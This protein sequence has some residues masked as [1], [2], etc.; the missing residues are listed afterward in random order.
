MDET[1]VGATWFKK[2]GERVGLGVSPYVAVRSQRTRGQ[3]V[4]QALGSDSL[5]AVTMTMRG[6]EFDH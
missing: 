5:G 6:F 4:G 2:V 3:V 1:W